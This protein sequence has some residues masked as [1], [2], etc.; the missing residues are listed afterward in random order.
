MAVN[1]SEGPSRRAGVTL[2][3]DG[4]WATERNPMAAEQ[5][6][7]MTINSPSVFLGGVAE[8]RQRFRIQA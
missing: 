2:W 6:N 7:E 5:G 4:S 3:E 1:P 8:S